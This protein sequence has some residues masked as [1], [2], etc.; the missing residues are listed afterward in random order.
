MQLDAVSDVTHG[1]C[2]DRRRFL[3]NSP[4]ETPVLARRSSSI[5]MGATV[6]FRR[7][8]PSRRAASLNA[9]IISVIPSRGNIQTDECVTWFLFMQ[10]PCAPSAH[11]RQS[12][13]QLNVYAFFTYEARRSFS[14]FSTSPCCTY[15]H[16]CCHTTHRETVD[17]TWQLIRSS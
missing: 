16:N 17:L 9:A 15:I 1:D 10:I 11:R 6:T 12:A 14:L 8:R 4:V 2:R 3:P 13:F 5:I 7:Q